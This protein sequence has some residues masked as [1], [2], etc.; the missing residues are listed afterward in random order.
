[1]INYLDRARSQV[2]QI[3]GRSER[4]DAKSR[5]FVRVAKARREAERRRDTI[6][7]GE[8][9][10]QHETIRARFVGHRRGRSQRGW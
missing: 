5:D 7:A 2:G 6:H 9:Q 8:P 1:M 4:R 10:Q 3:Q